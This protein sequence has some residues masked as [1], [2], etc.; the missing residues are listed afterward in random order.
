MRT[1]VLRKEQEMI[2]YKKCSEVDLK[3]VYEAFTA[4]FSDYILKMTIPW[5]QFYPSFFE[6]EGNHLDYSYIAM[7]DEKPV[8]IIFG[9][10]KNYE[11]SLTLRC[12][13]LCVA[14]EYRGLGVSKALFE[15]HRQLAV[16]LGCRQL[17]LEVIVGNDRAINFYKK[18]GYEKV[19]DLKYY[20][21]KQA[22]DVLK[23]CSYDV[24]ELDEN[25]V[26]DF[27]A[28]IDTHINWQNELD[29]AKRAG[30][31][32]SFGIYKENELVA[33]LTLSQTG[34]IF[35][36]YTKPAFRHQGMASS[37]LAEAVS[38]LKLDTLHISFPNNAALD[39]FVKKMG[40][41]KNDLTQY[42]MYMPL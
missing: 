5:E 24:Q 26:S 36:L 27:A 15:L 6:R 35:F 37:L 23:E 22:S 18:L 11:G 14:P 30:G 3:L 34:K 28:D 20:S 9:G 38:R 31:S 17:F 41:S 1:A 32:H 25:L 12:G 2:I 4:G 10:L 13:A 8:G 7:D 19:Y 33:A 29:Y 40:F 39:C 42:E 16:E 21:L